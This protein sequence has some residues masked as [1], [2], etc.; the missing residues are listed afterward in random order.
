MAVTRKSVEELALNVRDMHLNRPEED[1]LIQYPDEYYRAMSKAHRRIYRKIAKANPKVLVTETTF[2][3][4][5]SGLTYELGDFHFGEMEVYAPPGPPVGERIYPANPDSNYFGWWIDGTTLRFTI[6]QLYSPL[7]VRW[8]PETVDDV[9]PGTAHLL[10]AFCEDM[11]EYETAKIL[12]DK[13]GIA[14][15]PAKFEGLANAEWKGRPSDES[16][17]G[18]LGILKRQAASQGIETAAGLGYQPWWRGIG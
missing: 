14:I 4:S 7:Y 5:D 3:S 13:P 15:N 9:D 18:I 16:D 2:T 17:T 1:D 12:A 11:L 6:Q 8:A 10:P